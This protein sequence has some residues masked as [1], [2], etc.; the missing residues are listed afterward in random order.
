MPKPVDS[1]TKYVPALDGLR[2][3][4]V[5]A[6]L[7]YHLGAQWAP[8]G[9][10][11]VAVFFTLSGYLISTNLLKAKYRR[12]SFG[13]GTFW[14]RRFRRLVPAVVVTVIAVMLVT[15]LSTPE[16]VGERIGEALSALVYVNNWYVIAQGQ[17]YFDQFAGPGPLDHMWSLSIEEQFYL[18]WPLVLALLFAVFGRRRR[19]RWIIG[20]ATIVLSAASFGWMHYLTTVDADAT[21]IYEGTDTRAGGL[22][23]GAALAIF[24]VHRGGQTKPGRF[25]AEF[26]S[27][28]GVAVIIGLIATLPDHSPFLF[29]GG[30]VVL[31]VAT[32]A[33]IH[34]ILNERTIMARILGTAP[35]RWIGE[36]SYGIYLWHLPVTVY[37]PASLNENQLLRAAIVIALSFFLAAISWTMVEDPIRRNG[38]VDPVKAWLAAHRRARRDLTVG[39]GF[40]RPVLAGATVVLAAVAMMGLPHSLAGA[41]AA[42]SPDQT[43]AVDERPLVDA[44]S[45]AAVEARKAEDEG[46]ATTA[47]TTV[48]HVGDSTS[49]GM[50][51]EVQL[52]DPSDNAVLRYL[53]VGADDVVTSVFGARATAEGWQSYPSAVASVAELKAQGMPEGTCWVIATGVNDAANEAVGHGFPHPDRIELMLDQLKG[54][55]VLWA[56][57]WTGRN[58]GPWDTANM[59]PFNDALRDAQKK[60]ENLYLY[61]WAADVDQSWFLE[62]DLV[63]YNATGNAERSARF[64]D[65]LAQ[66]FPEKGKGPKSR[67]VTTKDREV[68]TSLTRPV[69]EPEDTDEP[70]EGGTTGD[71]VDGTG[72]TNPQGTPVEPTITS[73]TRPTTVSAV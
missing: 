63:H 68:Y 47:C 10:L 64:S 49:I 57:A 32:M 31:S 69:E 50:F 55:R 59:E 3:I 18:V 28:V 27:L 53:E 36:R 34:G 25:S 15:A 42:A 65:A 70:D 39:P 30:L 13:L 72:S 6:V 2:T 60:H 66:A 45:I 61:D 19:A 16:L 29:S 43:M 71:G 48:V 62:G 24:L 38:V 22:L 41:P 9:L 7:F 4:A 1:R 11:G 56:T 37:L 58:Y 54:E 17:S 35:M 44:D 26:A 23:L 8:G 51:S 20:T 33:V 5:M 67:I 12:D 14:L 40:P 46:P 73:G 21:R 52:P